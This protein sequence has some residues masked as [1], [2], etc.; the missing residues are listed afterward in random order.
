M[1]CEVQHLYKNIRYRILIINGEQYILDMEQSFWKV[2]FPFFF[3]VFPTPV[4]KVEDQ[5]IVEQLKEPK[6]EKVGRL[7]VVSLGG[8]AYVIG[9]LLAP[10]MD[11][12][13]VPMSPLVNTILLIIALILVVLLNLSISYN[14]K[15]KLYNVVEL[16]ELQQDKL[17]V[18]PNSIKHVFKL[19][20]VYIFL[21]GI[22]V[23]FFIGYI[24]TQ[25][26]MLLIF[27][28]VL[29]FLL[30]VAIRVTVEEG[31]TTVKFKS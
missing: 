24:E 29:W 12:F 14:R 11:Y 2:I 22:V 6:R 5:T 16:A 1:N 30:L 4:Y 21:L 15:K 10:L 17:R 8:I 23:L 27:T 3:W 7:I 19:S 25:N 20:A 31:H 26:I 28:S 13:E 9:I 18:C